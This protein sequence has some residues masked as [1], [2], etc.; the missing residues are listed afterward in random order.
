LAGASELR[1]LLDTAVFIFAVESPRRLSARAAAV[2]KNPHNIRELSSV[3]LT[4]IAIKATLGKLNISAEDARQAIQDMDIHI[5]PFTA[6]HAFRLF[7]LPAHHRD[8]FDR[9]IIAQAFSED[10]PVITSDETFSLYK[11]LKLIW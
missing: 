9:Q 6:D 3:S 7:E 8:P 5:L 4:E 1:A 2:L 11:G 10:V